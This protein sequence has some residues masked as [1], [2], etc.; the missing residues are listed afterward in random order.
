MGVSTSA[1]PLPHT[2]LP[3]PPAAT[4]QARAETASA[5]S[6]STL[7]LPLPPLTAAQT[8]LSGGH[9][10]PPPLDTTAALVAAV[11]TLFERFVAQ[12]DAVASDPSVSLQALA[13]SITQELAAAI[14]TAAVQVVESRRHHSARMLSHAAGDA[15]ATTA[16]VP[17]SPAA[18]VSS[19]QV[20]SVSEAVPLP[21]AASMQAAAVPAV[22]PARTASRLATA[23]LNHQKRAS[24]SIAIDASVGDAKRHR[25]AVTT[26]SKGAAELEG[27][28]VPGVDVSKH[29]H[30]KAQGQSRPSSK[31]AGSGHKGSG[32]NSSC[33]RSSKNSGKSSP[34]SSGHLHATS[35]GHGFQIGLSQGFSRQ[36]SPSMPSGLC[37]SFGQRS[38]LM[39]PALPFSPQVPVLDVQSNHYVGPPDYRPNAPYPVMMGSHQAGMANAFPTLMPSGPGQQTQ[40]WHG[41]PIAAQVTG[42]TSDWQFQPPGW[43]GID[44][45]PDFSPVD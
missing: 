2:Q 23:T 15:T 21:D 9:S 7:P 1:L 28:V 25:T 29:E 38:P 43:P 40:G 37:A 31:H 16:L 20:M 36:G 19:R 27:D 12:T 39:H 26:T 35:Q 30:S 34:V 6:L 8:P 3:S 45:I 11:G 4:A 42:S 22:E 5:V 14:A 10:Q 24:S 17:A 41:L 33:S 32:V 18:A 13:G 44:N